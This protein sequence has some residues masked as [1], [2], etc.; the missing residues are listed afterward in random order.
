MVLSIVIHGFQYSYLLLSAWLCLLQIAG[1][2][3]GDAALVGKSLDSDMIIEPVRGPLIPGFAAVKAAAKA[4]GDA[5]LLNS[6]VNGLTAMHLQC[7]HYWHFAPSSSALHNKIHVRSK[8]AN[9]LCPYRLLTGWSNMSLPCPSWWSIAYND[10]LQ[11]GLCSNHVKSLNKVHSARGN[12]NG[13][14]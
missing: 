13:S 6:S 1:I 10:L 14:N 4:A 11:S 3:T 2:L 8:K 9:L 7:M 12:F 5:F